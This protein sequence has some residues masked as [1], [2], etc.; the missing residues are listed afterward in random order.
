MK[1]YDIN[2]LRKD[3]MSGRF[4]YSELARKYEVSKS[5]VSSLV[6]YY[7]W[8]K[9]RAAGPAYGK[10]TPERIKKCLSCGRPECVNCIENEKRRSRA[11]G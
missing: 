11:D 8:A 9:E 4:S 7:G 3:Y 1:K 6:T 2:A 5:C 10:D